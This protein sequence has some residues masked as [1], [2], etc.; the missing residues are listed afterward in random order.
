M[1]IDPS[2]IRV[3]RRKLDLT[4]AELARLSGV[5][6]SMI[7]K[8]EAGKID[9]SFTAFKKI[10]EALTKA[11]TE[12]SLKASDIMSRRIISAKLEDDIDSVIRKM[13]RHEISQLPVF[14]EGKCVGLVTESQLLK[15]AGKKKKTFEVMGEC[16]PT[17][18]GETPIENIIG[19]LEYF[20]MVLVFE[21]GSPRGVITK[22]DIIK[23]MLSA[24]KTRGR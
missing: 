21:N 4:Q 5:S 24:S 18:P 23:G 19:L 22:N 12:S 17:V 13:L 9:P 2:Q 7:A 20:P 15:A 11:Q 1:E 6:Q 10:S 3:L 16:P 8:I 14:K